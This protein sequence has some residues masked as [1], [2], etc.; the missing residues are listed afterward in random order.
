MLVRMIP[1]K[2][3]KELYCTALQ[4][5]TGLQ[6][7]SVEIRPAYAKYPAATIPTMEK[8]GVHHFSQTRSG[9]GTSFNII[10]PVSRQQSSIQINTITAMEFAA[11]SRLKIRTAMNR[12]VFTSSPWS[13]ETHKCRSVCGV[14]LLSADFLQTGNNQPIASSS[15]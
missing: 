1:S 13:D 4:S 7:A 8:R 12:Q 14:S 15:L 10:Y 5:L 9:S 6:K 11:G 2:Y 3:A